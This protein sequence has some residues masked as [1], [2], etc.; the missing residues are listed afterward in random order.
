MNGL[1]FDVDT[2]AIHDGPG[3]RMAIYLKGCPLWCKW[4]HSPESRLNSQELI[5]MRDRCRMCGKCA[6]VCKREVHQISDS[7]H[8]IIYEKCVSCG[9][10]V[11]NCLYN[12]LAIK[13]YSISSDVIISKAK[14][15]KPFFDHSGGGVTLTGGEV[16]V[17]TDFAEAILSGCKDFGIHTAIETSGACD[18]DKLDRL[19]KWTD[20]VLYDIKLIDE[21]EHIKWTGI[22]NKQILDNASRISEYNVQIRVPLIPNITD[23]DENIRA[24]Y[25]FMLENGLKNVALLP[26]NTSASAKY[27]WLG[28]GYEIEG[29]SQNKEYLS[30]LLDIAH[31]K[32]LNAV[33]G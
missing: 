3:I 11:Q 18:W 28:I 26:Y 33:I 20:L 9:N 12:A 19:L 16:T 13:G 15:M 17:Q 10:C 25:D 31:Q 2:F 21:N 30:Q 5:F 14:R 32:G 23:T 8:V 1:I 6:F 7:K 29:E 22:S 27:E 24:I 4:C